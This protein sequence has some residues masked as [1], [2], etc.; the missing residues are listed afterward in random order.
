MFTG[1][2][3]EVGAVEEIRASGAIRE[4]SVKS[5]LISGTA[6]IGDS[7]SVDGVCLTVTKKS[8]RMLCFD[9]MKETLDNTTLGSL[10]RSQKVNLEPALSLKDGLGGHLVSLEGKATNQQGEV[11]LSGSGKVLVTTTL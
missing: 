10:K 11:V 9:V 1:I 8:D 4:I 6:G 5:D 7:V 2:V 3:K